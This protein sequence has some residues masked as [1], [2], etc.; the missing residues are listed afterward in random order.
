LDAL[1]F[2]E[3]KNSLFLFFSKVVGGTR[4]ERNFNDVSFEKKEILPLIC[5][6]VM[7]E[8]TNNVSGS[9]KVCGYAML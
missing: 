3:K 4:E 7:C 1:T 8:I 6:N 9:E 5:G 2:N